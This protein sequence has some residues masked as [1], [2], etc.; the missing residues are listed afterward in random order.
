M[1]RKASVVMTRTMS[2]MM[3]VRRNVV[4]GLAPAVCASPALEPNPMHTLAQTKVI[5]VMRVAVLSLVFVDLVKRRKKRARL[6][7]TE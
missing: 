4:V 3:L 6:V 7:V 1:R 2:E 5:H